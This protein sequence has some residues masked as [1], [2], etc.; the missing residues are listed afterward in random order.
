MPLKIKK[1]GTNERSA[2]LV[3]II[4]ALLV[5]VLIYSKIQSPT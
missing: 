4:E 2:L 3:E 5:G 1:H